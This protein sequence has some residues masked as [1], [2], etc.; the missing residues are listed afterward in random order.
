M[1]GTVQNHV[2]C[3][4]WDLEWNCV[5]KY[6]SNIC[7]QVPRDFIASQGCFGVCFCQV[8]GRSKGCL[9][10]RL[11]PAE[12]EDAGSLLKLRA[13]K[14]GGCCLTSTYGLGKDR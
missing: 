1:A 9:A 13:V 12:E 14:C 6:W 7:L 3:P 2:C 8:E 11:V 10:V 5:L 4:R